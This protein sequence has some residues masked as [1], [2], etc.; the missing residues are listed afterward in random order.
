MWGKLCCSSGHKLQSAGRS[1]AADSNRECGFSRKPGVQRGWA[2]RC[3]HQNH[4]REQLWDPG[5]L[6]PQHPGLSPGLPPALLCSTLTPTLISGYWQQLLTTRCPH[7][8]RHQLC[9]FE[10]CFRLEGYSRKKAYFPH[11]PCLSLLVSG[12]FPSFGGKASR[13]NETVVTDR[14]WKFQSWLKDGMRGEIKIT[15]P[16]IL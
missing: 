2:S 6:C 1:R 7:L 15:T 3:L 16:L 4:Q 5:T 13:Q 12:D 11:F 10:V 9:I 8:R 14:V